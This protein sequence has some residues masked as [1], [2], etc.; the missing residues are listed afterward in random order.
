[1][2]E[3]S[4]NK[5]LTIDSDVKEHQCEKNGK[6]C[7]LSEYNSCI[8]TLIAFLH[9]RKCPGIILNIKDQNEN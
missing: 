4:I 8:P 3:V 7:L 6:R 9:S 2:K 5:T 1:M